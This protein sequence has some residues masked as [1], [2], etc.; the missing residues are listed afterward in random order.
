[1]SHT[2]TLFGGDAGM[3]SLCERLIRAASET[4]VQQVLGGYWG[5]GSAWV[6]FGG[7]P[8]NA[9]VIGG[10]Q[11]AAEAALVEKVVNSIDARL[12]NACREA[13]VDPRDGKASPGTG[14]EAVARW[15]DHGLRTEQA[16][17]A[18]SI[19]VWASAKRNLEAEQITV[20]ATGSVD[21]PAC[22]SIADSGE[23]QE[24]DEFAATFC[25][26]NTGNKRSVSFVQGKHTMGGTGAL[27]FC[28]GDS[29]HAHR[30]QLIVSRRNPKFASAGDST[31]WGFTVVRRFPAESRE[32]TETY[33]YLAPGGKVLRFAAR[34]LRIFPQ[35]SDGARRAEPYGRAAGWG[36]LTKLYEYV[37]ST[38]I[39]KSSDTG[40]RQLSLLRKLELRMPDAMLP[41]K[42]YECR[43]FARASDRTPSVVLVGISNRLAGLVRP[44]ETLEW[45]VPKTFE[46]R[47]DGQRLRAQVWAFCEAANP[48]RGSDGVL[49][50]FSGQTHAALDDRFFARQSVGL[51]VLRR[52]LLVVVDCSEISRDHESS[53]V[54]TSRDRL[55]STAFAR[56]VQDRL[57]AKLRDHS[58]LK[59]LRNKRLR[60]SGLTKDQTDQTFQQFLDRCLL[61]ELPDLGKMLIDGTKISNP[62][63]PLAVTPEPLQLLRY[64][65]FFRFASGV[66]PFKRDAPLGQQDHRFKF[67]TDARD[68]YFDRHDDPGGR[69]LDIATP[70]GGWSNAD[71]LMESWYLSEGSAEMRVRLP[72]G[73]EIGDVVKL[74]LTITGSST[75]PKFVNTIELTVVAPKPPD[76]SGKTQRRRQ[77]RPKGT[78]PGSNTSARINGQSRHPTRSQPTQRCARS[79]PQRPAPTS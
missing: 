14:V 69:F 64:P 34:E 20:A 23:G 37:K 35:A 1:M 39:T 68:D 11:E 62:H 15:F 10:Q 52:H 44:G 4:E 38:Y 71:T 5:D 66:E 45:E 7:N 31:L 46:F 18:G 32:K 42:L 21:G 3:R 54:M 27:R 29:V 77:S 55:A 25:S 72:E 12:L 70:A 78:L 76:A 33:R 53:L 6:D 43:G 28:G 13:Q 16:S 30:L 47:V 19:A 9:S 40:N 22:I 50:A 26:L 67:K 58:A 56:D 48:W 59:Q 61:Q 8:A 65:T 60:S 49:F 2:P 63:A 79:T 74:R 36:T 24:P 17:K 57:A 41:V 73:A 51:G 75:K